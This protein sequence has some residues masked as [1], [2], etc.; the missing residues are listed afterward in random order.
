[1]SNFKVLADFHHQ[2]LY[3]SL[4][5]LFEKRLG[6]E[7]YRP[8]GPEWAH[9]GYWNVYNHP[10]TITQF[11]GLHQGTEMPKD[12]HG[13]PL[14]EVERKNLHYQ[15]ED[16]IYYVKDVTHGT[17]HRA[18]RLEKFKE[19]DFDILITSMPQHID[20]YKRL[21]SLHQ[22]KAKLIFQ[23]GN[24]WNNKPGVE[25]IMASTSSVQPSPHL[26][27]IQ[28]HQ[29]FDLDTFKYKLPE[30]HNI[31]YSY[32]HYMKDPHLLYNM[33]PKLPGWQINAYG[34]GMEQPLQGA[35][36][37]AQAHRRS[38]FTWHYKPGGDG[39]GHVIHGSYA[40]GRPALVWRKH[41]HG[42]L[43]DNL[44]EDG[45]T[46]IDT[47]N[48]PVHETLSLLR[49]FSQPEEHNKMCQAAYDRFKQVV[50]FDAE[51]EE[52]KKF[53]ERLK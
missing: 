36:S 46:C 6:W 35:E 14:P 26:N 18:V 38:A 49:R 51:F 27:M 11:L 12:V 1:M 21:I 29:E 22:P 31:I 5:L 34:A 52:M 13:E 19:M 9:Q 40:C 28:Y 37:M 23:V 8:I 48:K 32:V 42:C 45:V 20:S 43:A 39:Y 2:G 25:N 17:T 53:L 33:A 10:N 41:Y 44:F 50:N 24:R 7:L 4:Y 16:G 47:S 3:H 30:F 15:V